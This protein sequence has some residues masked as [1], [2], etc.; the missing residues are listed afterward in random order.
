MEG[1]SRKR[2]TF[3]KSFVKKI[4]LTRTNCEVHYDLAR[5]IVARQVRQASSSLRDGMVELRMREAIFMTA[6][7]WFTAWVNA[8]QPDLGLLLQPVFP[9]ADHAE[10]DSLNTQWQKDRILG[11]ACEG[12]H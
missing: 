2:Q 1:E 3:L 12:L 6:C 11:R 4:D 8:G 9:E 7:F 10:W 5:L